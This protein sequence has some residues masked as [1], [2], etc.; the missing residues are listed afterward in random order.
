MF[1]NSCASASVKCVLLALIAS[2]TS[3]CQALSAGD[4]FESRDNRQAE[5]APVAPDQVPVLAQTA[6]NAQVDRSI[7]DCVVLWLSGQRV[8]ALLAL[9]NAG[10]AST[11]PKDP[12]LAMSEDQ[13][14]ALDPQAADDLRQR[15]LLP[16][17]TAIREIAF[18]AREE[19]ISRQGTGDQQGAERLRNGLS[20]F[21]NWLAKP[22]RASIFSVLGEA[23][24][25]RTLPSIGT[26]HGR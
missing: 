4:H 15:H 18:A 14:A 9:E 5:P 25:S 24:A 3:G 8:P 10:D 23:I 17:A 13:I 22:D 16:R 7:D 11:Q 19:I 12:Y 26:S 1:S 20:V 21:S 2:C 6:A